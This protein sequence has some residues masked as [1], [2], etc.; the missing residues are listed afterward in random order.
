MSLRERINA[1]FSRTPAGVDKPQETTTFSGM[2]DV[3][4]VS[5]NELVHKFTAETDRRKIVEACRKMY[6]ADPR[7]KKMHRQLSRDIIKGGFVVRVADQRALS[8]AQDLQKRLNLNKRLDDYVRLSARD[9]DCFLQ[10]EINEALDIIEISRK[11]TLLTR[12]N[13]NTLDRFEDPRKAFW[14]GETYQTDPPADAIW[15]AEWETIHARWEHDEGHRYGT[16]M[17]AS[18]TSAF[19]RVTEGETDISV[20]RKTR[21]GLRYHHVVEGASEGELKAYKEINKA[22]LDNPLAAI[23]DF[24]SNKPGSLTAI[25]G[26]ATLDQIGDVE[27]HIATLFTG[28]EVPMELIAYG[29]D[30]NRDVLGEKK[31]E[32]DETLDVL[33]E[34][35][36]DQIIKPLLER[37]WLLK[38]IFPESLTYS[39]EWR[40][41]QVVTAADIRD[42]ADAAMRLRI[43]GVPEPVVKI[44]LVRFL[45]GVTIEMLTDEEGDAGA[46]DRMAELMQQLR[47]GLA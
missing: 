14:I 20:R 35:V 24:F 40:N 30:L 28:G 29:G 15:L 45:P 2:P 7:I 32:Y 27:H 18:A 38:G 23:A 13:S 5:P 1:L 46:A 6:A 22:A 47:G 44:M 37:Q 25:Q 3:K 9:G 43:L 8:V 26:D 16:P 34:W 11:P 21:S 41:K 17:L 10:A 42:I 39:I 33:R 36:S 12:R 31:V 19:K 4:S